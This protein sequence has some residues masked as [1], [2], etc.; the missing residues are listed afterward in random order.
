MILHRKRSDQ[1]GIKVCLPPG[2][3]PFFPHAAF[4]LIVAVRENLENC[5]LKETHEV[6]LKLLAKRCEA[7]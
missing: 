3:M 1:A 7:E 5:G 2:H 6:C 4:R